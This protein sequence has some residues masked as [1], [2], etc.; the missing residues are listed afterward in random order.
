[1]ASTPNRSWPTP[2]DN[3]LVRD[4]AAAIRALGDAIDGSV[5]IG[6]VYVGTRYYTSSGTFAK[7]DPFGDSSFDGAKMR[8][9]RVRMVGG[10]GGSGGTNATGSNQ[11]SVG[12]GGGGGAYAESFLT[13]I[14]GLPSSVT[15]TRGDGG[16]GGAA[17]AGGSSGGS[18]S[19]DALVVASGGSGGASGAALA[20]NRSFGGSLGGETA[21]GQLTINGSPSQRLM[22]IGT[23]DGQ[24]TG[25]GGG[26]SQLSPQGQSTTIGVVGQNFGGGATGGSNGANAAAKAGA[27]GAPGIVIVDVFS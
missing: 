22:Y 7:G 12:G 16:D 14:A 27:A 10:G 24:H 26:A 5:G 19:F 4:G 18:S 3:D 13:D 9:I 15:V 8:A 11:V 21:T 2:D 25:S 1:M 20:P 17:G 6:F 23:T